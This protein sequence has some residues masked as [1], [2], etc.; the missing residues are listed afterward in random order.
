LFILL[1]RLRLSC[2]VV[3]HFAWFSAVNV[4]KLFPTSP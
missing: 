3:P 2:A 4:P 1:V